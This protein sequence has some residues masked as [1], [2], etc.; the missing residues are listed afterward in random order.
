MEE[1]QVPVPEVAMLKMV[2]ELPPEAKAE[3][4]PEPEP[5]YIP[6]VQGYPLPDDEEELAVMDSLNHLHLTTENEVVDEEEAEE[7]VE[8]LVEKRPFE[9]DEYLRLKELYY[10]FPDLKRAWK[11]WSVSVTASLKFSFLKLFWF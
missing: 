2:L 5:V 4:K 6:V 8:K 1:E 7:W 10:F 3:L 11:P 9:Y